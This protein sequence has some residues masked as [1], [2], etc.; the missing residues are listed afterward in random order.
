ME[1]LNQNHIQKVECMKKKVQDGALRCLQILKTEILKLGDGNGLILLLKVSALAK[2]EGI[3][4][5]F[6]ELRS[7]FLEAIITL[8]KL[9]GML[10]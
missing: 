4:Q 3:L 5:R 9:K 8:E 10:I 2:G 6:Q 1:T 7:L